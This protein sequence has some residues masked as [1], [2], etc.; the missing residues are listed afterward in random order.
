MKS[1]QWTTFAIIFFIGFVYFSILGFGWSST[2]TMLSSTSIDSPAY[3]SCVIKTQSYIIPA[4]ILFFL[5]VAF[6]IC[7]GLEKK[8]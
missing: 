8:K 1:S 4:F 2:C 6:Q 5:S 3:T 7:A